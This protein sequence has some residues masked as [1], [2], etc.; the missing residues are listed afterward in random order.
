MRE[1]LVAVVSVKLTD[2]QFEGQTKGKLGNTDMGQ[3]VSQMIYEKLMT[4]FE[5]NPAVIKAIYAKALDAARAREAA[6]RRGILRAGNLLWREI[7]FQVNWPT[8]QTEIQRIQ[9][10]IL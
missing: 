4:F 3:M 9:R 2:A 6:R 5:E 1:G 10:F 7:P 8:A